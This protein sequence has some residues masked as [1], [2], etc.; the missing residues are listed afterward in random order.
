MT[1][2][3]TCIVVD[4]CFICVCAH[5]CACVCVCVCVIVNKF[6]HVV[7]ETFRIMKIF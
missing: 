5:T 4:V 6:P 2:E 7:I 3:M 1:F